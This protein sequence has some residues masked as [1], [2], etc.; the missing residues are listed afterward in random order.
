MRWEY[1]WEI[2]LIII[3]F[4]IIFYYQIEYHILNL[5]KQM[6]YHTLI[7]IFKIF[8]LIQQF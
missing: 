3:W 2:S 7:F 5:K 4:Q 6:V 8:I 1:I